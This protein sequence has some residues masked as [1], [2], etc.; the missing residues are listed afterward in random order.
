MVH[1]VPNLSL[2]IDCGQVTGLLQGC[3]MSSFIDTVQRGHQT[4][5][6]VHIGNDLKTDRATPTCRMACIQM[7]TKGIDEDIFGTMAVT[8]ITLC[9]TIITSSVNINFAILV[10][11]ASSCSSHAKGPVQGD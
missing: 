10:T 11:I 2:G 8:A 9:V 5:T 1:S 4:F 7:V 3:F 6:P